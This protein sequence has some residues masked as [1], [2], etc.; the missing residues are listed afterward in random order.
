M[1]VSISGTNGVTFPDSSLQG[2]AASPYVLKN[3]IINGAMVIDQRNAGA[4]VSNTS[5][6][7]YAVDRFIGYDF[8]DGTQTLQQ[9]ADAPAGF[10]NSLKMTI[11]SATT[12]NALFTGFQQVIEGFNTADLA[13]GTASAKT[14]TLSFWVKSSLTGTFGGAFGNSAQNRSYAFT[15]TISA[16]NTWE[17][18]TITVAGDTTGTWLTNN[19]A[20]VAVRWSLGVNASYAGTAG[21]WAA[22]NY[23]S[24]TGA[25][26][27]EATNGAT[28]QM[29]GV[30]LE[31]NTVATPFERRLY[32]QEL[33]NC[34][35]YAYTTSGGC[36]NTG[37]AA[38]TTEMMQRFNFPVLMR[39]APTTS[40]TLAGSFGTSDDYNA[41]YTATTVT[42]VAT[43]AST[44]MARVRLGGFTGLTTGRVYGGVGDTGTA[45]ITFTSEL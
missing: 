2:A 30:Q 27:L 16:A 39:V 33:A 42:L 15:Y 4:S 45:Q 21:S 1:P 40:I 17:Q 5:S 9:V 14:V 22:A 38:S 8:G 37:A 19:G 12:S 20:G 34:Q 6:G 36:S 35:R 18:K 23:F 13:W 7:V 41:D 28:W 3:R 10:V 43:R 24:A 32:N 25:L 11:T 44:I 31:Q 26:N 29:T